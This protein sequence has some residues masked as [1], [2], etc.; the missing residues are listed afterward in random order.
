MAI[1]LKYGNDNSKDQDKK[2]KTYNKVLEFIEKFK[3]KNSSILCRELLGL[4]LST[5]QGRTEAKNKNLFKTL[6]PEFVKNAVEFV[7]KII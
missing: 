7:E 4:D 2:E 5:E 1:G 3:Q 6:C